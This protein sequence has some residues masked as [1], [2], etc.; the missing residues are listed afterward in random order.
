MTMKRAF[1][2]ALALALAATA[3]PASAVELHGYWRSGIGGD[4]SGGGQTCFGLSQFG[5]KFRLGNECETY[6]EFEF[7]QNLYKDRT[8]L[9]FNF[10]GML[11]VQT[12]QK[13]T[14]ES[15]KIDGFN[16]IALRQAF[17]GAR[18]PQLG[19]T[20]WW[21][22]NR[23]YRRN[24]VHIIDFYY[25]DVSGPGAGV[26]DIKTFGPLKL[27]LAVFQ[28]PNDVLRPGE[29][30]ENTPPPYHG[31]QARW[32]M[33]RP[34]IRIYDIP[35]GIGTLEVGLD[36]FISA[37]NERVKN[38][39]TGAPLVNVQGEQMV[40]PWVTVQHFWPGL[41]GGFNKLAIQWATGSAAVMN[42]YPQYGNP[43]RATQFRVVEQLVVNPVEKFS[44]MF[45]LVYQNLKHRYG[46]DGD[47][48][49][50]V[51][52]SAGGRP[53]WNVTDWFKIPVEVGFQSVSPTDPNAD[54]TSGNR[55]LWKT[56]AAGVISAGPGGFFVRPEL[57]VFVTYAWWNTAAQQRNVAGMNSWGACNPATTTSPWGCATSGLTFGAQMEAWW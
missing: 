17:I 5:Y 18:V 49:S 48:N 28:S 36:L 34:D 25:W 37:P 1:L 39:T 3:A 32:Q 8:G 16:D 7:D 21:A 31:A 20:Y 52:W 27:A 56:T 44:G 12:T 6:G 51:Y 19:G 29:S 41:L 46:G 11:A 55:W 4:S 47:F 9:V 14:F 13:N 23:Y 22:G 50:G 2:A 40:S 15:L 24:D 54:G 30:Q 42:P 38:T 35:A 26:E 43:S 10:V 33:W 53:E 45:V 57:R